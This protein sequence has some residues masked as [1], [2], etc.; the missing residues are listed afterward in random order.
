MAARKTSEAWT[1]ARTG[2]VK[3]QC[4]SV[5]VENFCSLQCMPK[6]ARDFRGVCH[7]KQL[8]SFAP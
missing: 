2:K 7:A 5:G 1:Y 4:F 8:I 3:I 6:I